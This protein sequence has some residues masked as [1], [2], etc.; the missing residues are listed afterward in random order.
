MNSF[1]DGFVAV[2]LGSLP[3]DLSPEATRAAEEQLRQIIHNYFQRS[4]ARGPSDPELPR[5]VT[6][7][8]QLS[9]F[10]STFDQ[11]GDML[12]HAPSSREQPVRFNGG[13]GGSVLSFFGGRGGFGA[14][15]FNRSWL[16]FG[17]R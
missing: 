8:I 5:R 6:G 16:K 13:N 4:I 12:Q 14:S 11:L 1:Y 3:K 2:G 9:R 7:K 17:P 15:P 10:S